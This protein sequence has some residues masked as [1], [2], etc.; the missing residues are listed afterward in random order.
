MAANAANERAE[1]A[2]YQPRHVSS[3]NDALRCLALNIY[4]E[5]RSEPHIGQLAVGAVTLNR[6]SDPAFPQEICKVVRE[7]GEKRRHRC[8]FSWWCDGKRDEPREA[9]AWQRAQEIAMQLLDGFAYDPTGGALWYHADYVA[10]SWRTAKTQTRQIGR[11]VFYRRNNDVRRVRDY[12][13]AVPVHG[14]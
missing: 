6:V 11:H 14:S 10:P 8:Q 3:H 5:A 7:G 1:A 12:A 2:Q 9:E 4:W 13:D